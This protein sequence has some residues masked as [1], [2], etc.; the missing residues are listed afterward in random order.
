MTRAPNEGPDFSVFA[1]NKMYYRAHG[2][3]AVQS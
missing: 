1:V 3:Y 2:S